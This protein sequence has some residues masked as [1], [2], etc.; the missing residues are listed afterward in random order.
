MFSIKAKATPS[1]LEAFF[2]VLTVILIIS[3]AIGQ[4]GATPHIPILF[5]IILLIFYGLIIRFSFKLFDERMLSGA[6]A[7]FCSFYFCIPYVF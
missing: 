3:I 6:I 1:F 4:L 7:G 5:S 2:I